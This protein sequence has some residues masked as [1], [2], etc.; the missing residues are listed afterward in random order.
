MKTTMTTAALLAGLLTAG[1]AWAWTAKHMQKEVKLLNDSATALESSNPDL[2]SKLK[3]MAGRESA[4]A[5][6]NVKESSSQDQADAAILKDSANAL[7]QSRPDLAKGL[8][9]YA[10]KELHE[11]KRSIKPMRSDQ[12][13]T[14]QGSQG[15]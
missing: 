5:Q 10:A 12:S 9:R 8:D 1:P 7:R 3:D 15:Y 14:P 6:S 2:S 11:S 4:A 13:T